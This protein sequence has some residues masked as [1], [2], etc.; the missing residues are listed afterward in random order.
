MRKLFTLLI[1]TLLLTGSSWGQNAGRTANTLTALSKPGL[2]Q[3]KKNNGVTPQQYSNT[4]GTSGVTQTGIPGP[5]APLG[6]TSPYS[7]TSASGTYAAISGGTS[8]G[9][10]TDDEQVYTNIDIGFTFTFAGTAYTK[11]SVATNGFLAM[12]ATVATATLPISVSTGT[13]NVISALGVDLAAQAGTY[14][15]DLQYKVLG[16]S[17]ARTL[18][19]QW[20]NYKKKAATAGTDLFNFQIR[21]NE[22]DNTVQIVYGAFTVNATSS[23]PQVGLRA[24]SNADYFNR[25]AS[26]TFVWA[27][28]IEGIA[29]TSACTLTATTK[30]AS[31]LTWTWTPYTPYTLPLTESF[32]VLTTPNLPDHWS[33]TN[34]N[35]D[36]SLWK[37]IGY[38]GANS[39]PNVAYLQGTTTTANDWLFTPAMNLLAGHT[40]KVEFYYANYSGTSY[41]QKLIVGW[42]VRSNSTAMTTIYTN[43]N[44]TSDAFTYGL[45]SFTPTTTGVY[46]VGFRGYSS[47][48]YADYLFLDDISV[49]EM[50]TND[51]GSTTLLNPRQIPTGQQMPWFGKVKNF[52][53][54]VQ[55][56]PVDTKLRENTVLSSTQTNTV[57]ALASGA[58]SVLSGNF[59]LSSLGAASSFDLSLQTNLTGDLL[60]SNDLYTNYTRPCVKSTSYAWDDGESEGTVGFN[61]TGGWLGQIYYFSAPTTIYSCKVQW[62]TIP[63]SLSGNSIEVYNVA[64][65]VP[66][67]K[68]GNIVTG[69]NLTASDAEAWRSYDATTPLVLPAGT[70]WIGLHQTV[71]LA[72]TYLVSNDQTGYTS[73]N[74]FT[75]HCFYSTDGAAWTDYTSSSLFM[76]NMIRP[77]FAVVLCVNPSNV[78]ATPVNEETINVTWNLNT[79]GNNVL[80]AWS[81]DGVFGTP[82]SGHVYGANDPIPGGGTVLQYG[83]GTTYTHTPDEPGATTYYKLWSYNGTSY[84]SGYPINATTPCYP[85]VAPISENFESGVFPP[86]CW[87]PLNGS[88]WADYEGASGYGVGTH[89]VIAECYYITSTTP[90]DLVTLKFD[91]SLLPSPILKFDYAYAAYSATY[92]DDL[93]IYTSTDYGTTWTLALDMPGGTTGILNTGGTTTSY[94][95][96]TAAQW[97]TRT[98]NLTSA[99]NRVKF[100]CTSGNGN[101]MYIDNVKVTQV[102]TH[103]AAVFA[104]DPEQVFPL[105]TATPKATILNNGTSTETNFTATMTIGSYTSTKTIATL[106]ANA[107]T[108]VT[109][110]PWV[111]ATGDYTMNVCTSLTGDLNPAN[112]CMSQPVKVLPINKQVYGY[113]TFTTTNNG[114]IK[115]NLNNPGAI[116]EIINEYPVTSY[117][118]GGSWAN[119]AWYA[120]IYATA[121]PYNLVT[122]DTVTGARN[123][124]GNMGVNINAMSYNTANSTMYGAGYNGTTSSLYTINLTTGVAT[125]VA[126]IGERLI[127]NMAINNAGV[128]YAVDLSTSK[129][130]TIDLTTGTF[131]AIGALGFT[132]QYAQDMEF[133]RGTNQLYMAAYGSTGQ[134]RWVDVT[135]GSTMLIGDF[136]GGAEVTGFAIPY[137][138]STTPLAVS[139]NVTNVTCFGN[140]NGSIITTVT[141]G[142]PPYTYSWSNGAVTASVSGLTAGLYAVT[143]TD[144]ASGTATGS[145]TVTQPATIVLSAAV[146]PITCSGS[147]NGAIDLT[148]IGEV[149]ISGYFWS[150]GA[151]TEDISGLNPGTYYVTVT[152]GSGCQKTGNWTVT[153]PDPLGLSGT[154][155][156]TSCNNSCDG[157]IT[158]NVSGGTTPY[159]YVWSNG[160]T[161]QNATGLCAGNYQL[162][163]TDAHQCSTYKSW[164]IESPTAIGISG[165]VTN[166]TCPGTSNGA[167]SLNVTGG[168]APYGFLQ[169]EIIP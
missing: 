12:G 6:T 124:I 5:M 45:A 111:N 117:P 20:T 137:Q 1:V 129:L 34:N 15:S 161:T 23:A 89:A 159:S 164:M 24:A 121:A 157:T 38:T 118:G 107:S 76:F 152:Y 145:W 52:G 130:G 101:N 2:S 65:N 167:I 66:T 51:V 7:F 86:Y 113:T 153:S 60:P 22:A 14:P 162:T 92:V 132:A 36:A 155:V 63:G 94:F 75:G 102:Y 29:N 158:V 165:T 139:G 115:F 82:V 32:D 136:Q 169:Q 31:G 49:S 156:A 83:S 85:T 100:T 96:P 70:Y 93:K 57:T 150:N 99:V 55:T 50:L 148:V 11:F 128:C 105:G 122:F 80:I 54:A 33:T 91:A 146:T 114:P 9:A 131:T 97:G 127:I 125:F 109:F 21:L 62:G 134:L 141:G 42:G 140:A 98:I 78:A 143:V 84:S 77:D 53:S 16:T 44:I 87:P 160:Q 103:D 73:S 133:D 26:T 135:T 18:V 43:T 10:V 149:T 74:F 154:P 90:F 41:I 81:D 3:L 163:V 95:I 28:S 88:S 69:I 47:S 104:L 168:N 39:L 79:S 151:T 19:V 144:A 8:I 123:V 120:S 46:Y 30:P 40:Y 126:S 142:T 138:T 72:G 110:D 108:V 112:D 119:G 13:N 67:T 106:A 64:A 17:P 166:A 25:L 58:T 56:F 48:T 71:S 59:D 116:T 68:F 61:T 37:T 35:T 147:G 27:S 4:N